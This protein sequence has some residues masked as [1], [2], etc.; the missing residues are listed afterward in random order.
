MIVF[1]FSIFQLYQTMD[2]YVFYPFSFLPFNFLSFQFS[3][4]SKPNKTLKLT[5]ESIL[6]DIKIKLNNRD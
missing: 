6:N 4:H 2:D 1:F 3:F 5:V